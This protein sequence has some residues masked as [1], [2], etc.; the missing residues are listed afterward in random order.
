MMFN[1]EGDEVMNE[2][3]TED[4]FQAQ[5]QEYRAESKTQVVCDMLMYRGKG[6]DCVGIDFG[7]LGYG[8]MLR[9]PAEMMDLSIIESIEK[10]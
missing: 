9:G 5:V 8:L 7:H 3:L 1:L 10:G 2:Q 6:I 4:Q